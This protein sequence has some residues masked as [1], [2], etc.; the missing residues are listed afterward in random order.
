MIDAALFVPQ[1]RERLFVIA[2]DAE[3]PIPA[4]LVAAGPSRTLPSAEVW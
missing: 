2:I 1:S 4:D 3:L